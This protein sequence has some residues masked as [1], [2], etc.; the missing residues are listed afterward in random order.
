VV[1]DSS[2]TAEMLKVL[3]KES[4]AAVA[5]ATAG[6]EALQIAAESDFDVILSDISMPGMDGFEFLRNVKAS[7]RNANVPVVALTGFGRTEDIERARAAGFYA[8]LTNPLD[9]DLL[10]ATLRDVPSQNF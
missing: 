3:L 8:H 1:D 6:T 9:V 2:D 4:G 10:L 5:V 7:T